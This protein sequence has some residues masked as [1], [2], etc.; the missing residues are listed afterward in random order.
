MLSPLLGAN[1]GAA[2]VCVIA[3]AL[4]WLVMYK[5]VLSKIPIVRALAGLPPLPKKEA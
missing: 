1:L 5:V 4:G 3:L 2:L